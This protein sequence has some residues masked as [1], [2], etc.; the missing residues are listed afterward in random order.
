MR[1]TLRTGHDWNRMLYMMDAESRLSLPPQPPQGGSLSARLEILH[2]LTQPPSQVPP[3]P[4]PV[5]RTSSCTLRPCLRPSLFNAQILLRNESLELLADAVGVS[6]R[7]RREAKGVRCV[8]ELAA[9]GPAQPA[10]PARPPKAGPHIYLLI[11]PSV[12]LVADGLRMD[13]SSLT[14]YSFCAAARNEIAGRFGGGLLYIIIHTVL[15]L[16]QLPYGRGLVRAMPSLRCPYKVALFFFNVVYV[17]Q[18][19]T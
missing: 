6:Y 10:G 4:R 12:K 9:D 15:W 18:L 16:F 1:M 8:G 3:V 13:P 7:R 11:H 2:P 19:Y 5:T 14:Y 17:L